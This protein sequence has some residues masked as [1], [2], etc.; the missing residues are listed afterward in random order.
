MDAIVRSFAQSVSR[1]I[2]YAVEAGMDSNCF[3]TH[4]GRVP[5]IADEYTSYYLLNLAIFF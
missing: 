3:C 4:Y 2:S 5:F 1:D